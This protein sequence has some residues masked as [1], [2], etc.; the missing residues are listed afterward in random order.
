M[1]GLDLSDIRPCNRVYGHQ[2]LP[3]GPI[4]P[5]PYDFCRELRSQALTKASV[6]LRLAGESDP[7][8]AQVQSLKNPLIFY[9]HR[10]GAPNSLLWRGAALMRFLRAGGFSVILVPVV[11]D[12]THMAALS[13]PSRGLSWAASRCPPGSPSAC[14]LPAAAMLCG[15][16]G[17]PDWQPEGPFRLPPGDHSMAA[18]G[19]HQAPGGHLEAPLWLSVRAP[20]RAPLM[21]FLR[22]QV[23]ERSGPFRHPPM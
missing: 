22:C 19:N 6:P 20:S 18:A 8:C 5:P 1:K 2:A 17:G 9:K 11:L 23:V 13:R 12:R 15:L 3:P 10:S 14:T 7:P 4:G 16:G 21:R